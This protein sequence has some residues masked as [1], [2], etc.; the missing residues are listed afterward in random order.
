MK[1]ASTGQLQSELSTQTGSP[2]TYRSL[3]PR[4]LGPSGGPTRV[5]EGPEELSRAKAPGPREKMQG[6]DVPDE[7]FLAKTGEYRSQG[8]M[9]IITSILGVRPRGAG[10]R[11]QSQ[12]FLMRQLPDARDR[13]VHRHSMTWPGPGLLIHQTQQSL[14]NTTLT[15]RRRSRITR[16]TP[17]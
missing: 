15:W 14:N 12:T 9:M 8:I 16:R 7:E 17:T 4:P 11:L 5:Q 13:R 2:R 10:Q 1:S 6:H 3:E